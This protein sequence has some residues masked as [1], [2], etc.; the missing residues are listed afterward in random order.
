MNFSLRVLS[1]YYDASVVSQP[2]WLARGLCCLGSA[3][4]K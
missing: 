2:A 1:F 3:K 4:V